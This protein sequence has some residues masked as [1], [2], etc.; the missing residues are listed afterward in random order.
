MAIN[1]RTDPKHHQYHNH[2][3]SHNNPLDEV[4]LTNHYDD[5]CKV[6]KKETA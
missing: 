3:T 5:K 6:C 1:N 4:A 2:R